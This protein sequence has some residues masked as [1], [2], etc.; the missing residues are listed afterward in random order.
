[1]PTRRIWHR[2]SMPR[3]PPLPATRLYADNSRTLINRV[4][5]PDLGFRWT[6]NPYRGC[7]HGCI[8]CY[9]RP[10]HEQLGFSS[11]LDFETRITVKYHAAEILR[12]EL[13]HPRW[14]AEPIVMCGVT[15][16]YQPI[17]RRLGITRACLEVMAESRQPVSIATKNRLVL[18]D[19]DLLK[20]LN[21]HQAASVAISLTTLDPRL[22]ACMEPRASCPADR[23]ATIRRLAEAEVPVSVLLAPIIPG[24]NDCEI[25]RLLQEAAAAG[26]TAA[27]W[28]LIRLPHQNR[29]LFMDW[30]RRWYPD[31]ARRIEAAIRQARAGRLSD[32]SYG[33]RMRGSGAHAQLIRRTFN[34]FCERYGLHSYDRSQ[35]AAKQLSG[36]AF[37]RPQDDGS[38]MFLFEA[39]EE[40][41]ELMMP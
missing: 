23:L 29:F 22:S 14:A 16:A 21:S 1:M 7:E 28:I 5:S 12:R 17:E 34:V 39:G 41:G 3:P 32:A 2:L 18:R 19:L 30:L 13:T 10:Y 8:Y 27:G 38:Q 6:I 25:P 31:R 9:A 11:G 33:S 35:T 36:A 15:D 4:D 26:A 40:E 24:L 37:R 20:S